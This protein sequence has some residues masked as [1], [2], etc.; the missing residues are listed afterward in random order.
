MVGIISLFFVSFSI[1]FLTRNISILL[2]AS[3]SLICFK[4]RF[5]LI[6]C[7]IRNDYIF[8]CSC[9]FFWDW[10][11]F[12]FTPRSFSILLQ[13]TRRQFGFYGDPMLNK[14]KIHNHIRKLSFKSRINAYVSHHLT[15]KQQNYGHKKYY[16]SDN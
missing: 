3:F 11:F 13:L 2:S 12:V 15:E 4:L 1:L 8:S 16:K 10:L 7:G 5:S 14:S 9:L 6:A